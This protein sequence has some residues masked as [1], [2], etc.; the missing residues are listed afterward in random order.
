MIG[1]TRAVIIERTH[2]WVR[3]NF[4]YMRPDWPLP[5]DAP[6]LKGGVIDSVGVVE[7]VAWLEHDLGVVIPEHEITEE[8]FG[9]LGAIGDYLSGLVEA[10]A[11]AEGAWPRHVA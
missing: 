6:L 1:I 4:L 5:E 2:E 10:S 11:G 3:E 7:L 8:H 9:T